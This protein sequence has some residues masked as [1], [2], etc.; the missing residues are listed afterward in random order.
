MDL[1]FSRHLLL[2]SPVQH[3]FSLFLVTALIF[4]W[5]PCPPTP[6]LQLGR[7]DPILWL[8]AWPCCPGVADE[9]V[10]SLGHRDRIRNG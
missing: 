3:P 7:A 8:Q 4:L 10:P 1:G 6:T 5:D 2:W 9:C